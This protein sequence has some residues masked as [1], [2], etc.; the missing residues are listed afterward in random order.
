[1]FNLSDFVTA[2]AHLNLTVEAEEL[3]DE[4]KILPGEAREDFD[5]PR[6]EGIVSQIISLEPDVNWDAV[7]LFH[8][9]R[10]S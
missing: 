6:W 4:F 1:M 8:N 10:L 2:A 5:L 7:N 3:I 9:S